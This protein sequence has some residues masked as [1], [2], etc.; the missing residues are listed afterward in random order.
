MHP[1]DQAS[2]MA[3]AEEA[4]LTVF[5]W[6]CFP[7]KIMPGPNPQLL[8][9]IEALCE[10]DVQEISLDG[11][12]LLEKPPTPAEHF[13]KILNRIDFSKTYDDKSVAQADRTETD[14][15]S[16]EHVS[17]KLW[18]SVREATRYGGNIFLIIH[19]SMALTEINAFIDILAVI[20]E[21][22]YLSVFPVASEQPEPN[23]SLVLAGKKRALST[24]A[25]ILLKGT[26]RLRR[27]YSELADARSRISASATGDRK[28]STQG[29]SFHKTLM[30]LR[31]EW[32]LKLHQNT[33]LGDVSLRPIGS[34]FRE[35]GNFEVRESDLLARQKPGSDAT[36]SDFGGSVDVSAIFSLISSEPFVIQNA[37]P[38]IRFPCL[39]VLLSLPV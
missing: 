3:S 18:A 11:R 9:P 20:K 5:S 15:R 35:S 32:R 1:Y 19:F 23:W 33:I 25:E 24:A 6:R 29:G 36:A 13:Q 34:R 30:Q 22:R 26:E 14:K 16:L 27:R 12:E 21:G 8:I 2:R 4:L 39:L 28:K 38:L 17:P 31:Q 10:Y 37:L 7:T